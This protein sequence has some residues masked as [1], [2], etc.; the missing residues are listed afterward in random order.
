VTSSLQLVITSPADGSVF[1]N[2]KASSVTVGLQ[3]RQ[4]DG[5]LVSTAD[6]RLF[7]APVINGVVGTYTPAPNDDGSTSN[8]FDVQKKEY[9]F[10]LAAGK[11]AAG[12]WSLQVVVN[13]TLTK[14]VKITLSK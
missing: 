14:E 4:S 1:K 7:V 2:K 9:Q 3:V 12:V 5:T 8:A 13:G 11:M 10:N 6:A